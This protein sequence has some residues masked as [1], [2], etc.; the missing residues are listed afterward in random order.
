M[1]KNLNFQIGIILLLLTSCSKTIK[2]SEDDFKWIP[3]K[4]NE[5]LVFNSSTGDA[6]TIFLVGTDQHSNPSDPLDVFPT[7]LEHFTILAKYSDPSSSHQRYLKG[8][9][10]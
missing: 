3:Y 1:I 2:L 4:G 7:K 5:T 6:D 9:F 8:E 10:L